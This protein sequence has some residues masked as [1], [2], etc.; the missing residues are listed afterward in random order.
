MPAIERLSG[1]SC[2]GPVGRTRSRHPCALVACS[3]Q[4]IVLHTGPRHLLHTLESSITIKELL[5]RPMAANRELPLRQFT[6]AR[7]YPK[8]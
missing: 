2:R 4:A 5:E 3:R 7:A 6:G 8:H 1:G